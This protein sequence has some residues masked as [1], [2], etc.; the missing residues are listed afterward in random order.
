MDI[1]IQLIKS[2]QGPSP[3]R[4]SCSENEERIQSWIHKYRKID[5][6]LSP[7]ELHERKQKDPKL[8]KWHRGP[9]RSRRE[10]V[11][12]D[13]D[14]CFTEHCEILSA[15]YKETILR[16]YYVGFYGDLKEEHLKPS[17]RATNFC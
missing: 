11:Q 1:F 14:K 13:S 12:V 7:A 6:H 16:M 4:L 5:F 9:L 15:K 3:G 8:R 17:D 2:C 10:K